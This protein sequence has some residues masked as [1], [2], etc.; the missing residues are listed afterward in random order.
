[1][2]SDTVTDPSGAPLGE[3]DEVNP[4]PLDDLFERV[5]AELRARARGQR[6]GWKGDETLNTTALIHETY[7]KLAHTG[8]PHWKSRAHFLAVASRAMRQI[9]VDYG[10]AKRSAK[11]GGSRERTTV[12]ALETH[13]AP[14]PSDESAEAFVRLEASLT[15]L[16]EANPRHARIVE[17]RFFGDMTIADTA[18]ALGLSPASVKRG[19]AIA[20]AWLYR[21]LGRS[22]G[23]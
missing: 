11:R 22:R 6:R 16:E 15:R 19:W 18:E 9:L 12:G 21:D 17:C 3:A 14:A 13:T 4:A 10:R 7:L 8:A 23:A 1:M 20:K 5:Y 2:A